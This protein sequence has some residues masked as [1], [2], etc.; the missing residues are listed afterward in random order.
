MILVYYGKTTTGREAYYI[1][2]GEHC[3]ASEGLCGWER[4]DNLLKIPNENYYWKLI[5]D[6]FRSDFFDD[7]VVF[8][9]IENIDDLSKIKETHPELFI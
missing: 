3:L 4:L 7:K 6:Q 8:F 9:T 2:K 1:V 5:S